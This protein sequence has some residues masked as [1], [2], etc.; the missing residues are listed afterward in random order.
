VRPKYNGKTDTSTIGGRLRELG[1]SRYEE[2]LESDHWQDVRR[3]YRASGRPWVCRCGARPKALHHRTYER[4]GAELL[5]D[6]EPICPPC[7][8]KLHGYYQPR[9]IANSPSARPKP[10]RS[11]KLRKRKPSKPRVPDAER[12]R[13][14]A[15]ASLAEW[16]AKGR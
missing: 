14:A 12:R 15:E 16:R 11:R 13:L 10:R 5:D 9:S 8:R 4:L 2:Y 3:R 1:F 6:L 7:H